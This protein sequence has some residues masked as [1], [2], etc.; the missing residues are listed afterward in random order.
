MIDPERRELSHRAKVVP[1]GPQVFD[2]LLHL[3]RNRD[4]VVSKDDLLQAVWHGRIVS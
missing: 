1:V 3:V 2:L 4:R